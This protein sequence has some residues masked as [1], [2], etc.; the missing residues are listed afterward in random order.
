MVPICFSCTDA[1]L[2]MQYD[3]LVRH[4]TS[5]DLDLSSNSDIDLLRS[6]FIYLDVSRR[7]EHDAAKIMSLDFLVQKL[8]V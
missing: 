6:I 3:L 5:R 4:M 7:E 8:F 2:D 1:S